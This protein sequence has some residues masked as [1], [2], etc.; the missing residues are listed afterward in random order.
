[1]DWTVE[2]NAAQGYVTVRTRGEFTLRD[3][4]QMIEDIVSRDFWRPGTAVLF[5]HREL[6]FGATGI[7]A[8]RQASEN[9][10]E[11]DER[12]GRGRAAVLMRSPADYGRGRQFEMLTDGRVEAQ[13]QIFLDE[14]EALRWLLE[15]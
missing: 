10:V 4:L 5:D 1:M 12:I 14:D 3:H 15:R 13:V 9:H 6:D 8:M 7:A 11:H 2:H